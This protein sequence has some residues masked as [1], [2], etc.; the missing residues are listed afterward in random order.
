MFLPFYIKRATWV[1]GAYF[2]SA[3]L[4]LLKEEIL[5]EFLMKETRL[6]LHRHLQ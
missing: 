5:P 3:I 1:S 4:C 2:S 6:L